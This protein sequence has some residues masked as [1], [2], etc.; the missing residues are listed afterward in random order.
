MWRVLG[1][2]AVGN[3]WT[4]LLAAVMFALGPRIASELTIT[5]VE[6]WPMAVAP[7][8]L[9]PLVAPDRRSWRW[10]ILWS[11]V[12]LAFCGGVNAVATGATLVLPTLWFLTRTPSR[13]LARCFAGW[14]VACLLAMA[15]WLV[16]L[17]LLGRFSP[18]FL[19]WIEGSSITSSTAS[20]YEALKGTSAWLAFLRSD[21]GPQWP[22]GWLYVTMP[23]LVIG[24]T[25]V[26]ACGLL[27]IT[28]RRTPERMLL[29]ISV[30]VGLVLMTAG[31]TSAPSAPWAA[32]V[33]DVLDTALAAFRNAHK[34]D[35]VVR[36]PLTIGLAS[37]LAVF[38]DRA[39]SWGAKSWAVPLIAVSLTVLVTAP[40]VVANLARG[41]S[42]R[43]V[44]AYWAQT[45]RWLDAQPQ[46]GAALV[47]P[48]ASFA[49]FNW[50]S[51]KDNPLQPLMRRPMVVRDAV[52]LGSAGA[53][54]FLDGVQ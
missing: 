39:R 6:V 46:P 35:V 18:P 37:A 34:F 30:L 23:M 36:I 53:T 40:V 28:L 33:Q 8:V 25:I 26:A 48:A 52:P 50:G 20:A 3:A 27:G 45:A 12:A 7:W 15:W 21:T 54:R 44:P 11:A 29:F 14:L 24:S 42:Y 10:R 22:G 16:P 43:E 31:H 32:G 17:L 47:L 41:E 4:R 5:S 19:D 38:S 51:T 49:D 9:W 13:Q 1:A 2:F